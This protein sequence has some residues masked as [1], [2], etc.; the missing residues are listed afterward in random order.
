VLQEALSFG[1]SVKFVRK[2]VG[3][4]S[5][6]GLGLD[7]AALYAI[8]PGWN[9]G[10]NLQDITTTFLDWSNT[11]TGEREY[12]TPTAKLGTAYTRAIAAIG[13]SLTGALDIDFR[14]EDEGETSSFGMGAV[15]GD[16]RVGLEYF[17]RDVFALRVGTE[18]VNDETNPFTAGA[19]FRVKR[20][21]FDYAFRNH[22]DLEESHR[23]SGGVLF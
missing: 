21:S 6:W 19:G 7:A 22:S 8:Q 4:Y 1:G 20:L 16:V 14:F 11:P 17:Y 9:V 13:G 10:L 2:S 3:D 15:S 5:A 18:R 23:I 12:I